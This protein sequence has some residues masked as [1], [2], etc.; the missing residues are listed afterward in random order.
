MLV[1]DGVQ[2]GIVCTATEPT[3]AI[4]DWM[5]PEMDGPDVCRR[6]ADC[7][8]RTCISCSSPRA[9]AAAGLPARR[10]ADDYIVTFDPR[11]AR[12]AGRRVL[13][14]SRSCE[15][16][17]SCRRRCRTSKLHGLLPICSYCKR[18]A[19]TIRRQQ[20]EGH[21]ATFRGAAATASAPPAT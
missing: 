8:S 15:R 11:A 2:P 16:V 5:M 21:I 19:V 3:L 17:A 14:C 20:V 10:R 12:V 7:R 13:T 9:K 6:S 4:L 18:I 1:V